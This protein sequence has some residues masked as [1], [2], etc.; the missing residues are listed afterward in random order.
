MIGIDLIQSTAEALMDKAAIE[1]PQDYLDGL[2]RAAEC[3]DGDLSSF[4]LKAML[5]NYE[6]AREDRRA[7]VDLYLSGLC[8]RTPQFR[9]SDCA[10]DCGPYAG[11]FRG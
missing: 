6:A 4:V 10:G 9:C 1:I 5:E 11:D 2:Q 7:D 8:Q 3:E